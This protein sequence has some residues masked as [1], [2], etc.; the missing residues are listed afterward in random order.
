MKTKNVVSK[1]LKRAKRR[2]PAH[3]DLRAEA[4][5]T[6][7]NSESNDPSIEV[8]LSSILQI[9]QQVNERREGQLL[10]K[11]KRIEPLCD[12]E[13]VP[14]TT[15][16]HCAV[17]ATKI[18][19]D[20]GKDMSENES[21]ISSDDEA[22][23]PDFEIKA[24]KSCDGSSPESDFEGAEYTLIPSSSDKIPSQTH[25][26]YSSSQGAVVEE[27]PTDHIRL[28][29]SIDTLDQMSTSWLSLDGIQSPNQLLDSIE[30]LISETIDVPDQDE[31]HRESTS[32]SSIG[33]MERGSK[34]KRKTA[35]ERADEEIKRL[36]KIKIKALRS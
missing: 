1:S 29:D 25:T 28:E 9:K 20:L 14:S 30:D 19:N 35:E 7:G 2:T 6:S 12:E 21:E 15:K 13:D 27:D 11:S 3:R 17:N 22:N 34:R 18:L 24:R 8:S 4:M 31:Q 23:D 36:M 5:V 26:T 16:R 33:P 32:T 10:L